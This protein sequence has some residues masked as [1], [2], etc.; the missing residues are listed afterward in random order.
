MP[1]YVSVKI[2]QASILEELLL[3]N[4]SLKEKIDQVQGAEFAERY[5]RKLKR[6]ARRGSVY[7]RRASRAPQPLLPIMPQI[8]QEQFQTITEEEQ[9][10][11]ATS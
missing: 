11:L 6:D 10:P 5:M 2:K 4:Q 8:P 3:S 1:R 7:A 9:E